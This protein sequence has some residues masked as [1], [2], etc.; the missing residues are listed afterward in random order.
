MKNMV[1]T[2]ITGPGQLA[3]R[4]SFCSKAR[5]EV[6]KLI[7]GPTVFICD[8]CVQVCTE[9]IVREKESMLPAGQPTATDTTRIVACRLCGL[10]FPCSE[11]LLVSGRGFL[12]LG[13]TGEIEACLAEA[14]ES[15]R[16][17]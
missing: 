15:V 7:A 6:Q 1:Q 16:E 11:G 12:C 9:I 2:M 13:C 5:S 3:M 4:C 8:E 14:R 17:Q 10:Q